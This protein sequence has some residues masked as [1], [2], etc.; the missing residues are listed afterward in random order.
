MNSVNVNGTTSSDENNA[1]SP[2]LVTW[3]SN[4]GYVIGFIHNH[5]AKS[6]TNPSDV[7]NGINITQMENQ[8]SIP[9]AQVNF[10]VQN[11][12]STIV[13]S[14]SIYTVTIKDVAKFQQVQNSF[15]QT[16]ANDKWLEEA[17]IYLAK[18][19]L[20]TEQDAGEYALL[21]LFG[22]AIHLNKQKVNENNNNKN[23][24][25]SNNK[26]TANNPC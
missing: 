20:G 7:F 5:P 3:D 13:T 1:W 24:N 21:K 16:A 12:S 17:K 4:K 10:Y 19:S 6:P 22:D 23:I 9:A 11:F 8:L 15:D 25:I 14:Q 2:G 18:K 26:P